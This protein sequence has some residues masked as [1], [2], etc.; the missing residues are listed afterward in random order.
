MTEAEVAA[1]VVAEGVVAG[2]VVVVVV[3]EAPATCAS[4]APMVKFHIALSDV[5]AKKRACCDPLSAAEGGPLLL[6]M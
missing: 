5:L 4:V 1:V 2:S 3:A 6:R